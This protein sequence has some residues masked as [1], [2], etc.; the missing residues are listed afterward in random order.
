MRKYDKMF[1]RA[2]KSNSF[3]FHL[4]FSPNSNREP[5]EFRMATL[6]PLVLF[7]VFVR[8]CRF[9]WFFG[10]I[11]YVCSICAGE[12]W[13]QATR[14]QFSKCSFSRIRLLTH[15]NWLRVQQNNNNNKRSN[16]KYF[17]PSAELNRSDA[18]YCNDFDSPNDI[19]IMVNFIMW[20]NFFPFRLLLF[21]SLHFLGL[22]FRWR[23]VS[24]NVWFLFCVWCAIHSTINSSL[25]SNICV[26]E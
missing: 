4:K 7:I 5:Y 13:P 16:K 25:V 17:H 2:G 3:Y 10:N 23:F 19:Q 20:S 9:C 22:S 1:V 24:F 15:W 12:I 21:F 11:L 18:F 14:F 6:K 8:F 26:S